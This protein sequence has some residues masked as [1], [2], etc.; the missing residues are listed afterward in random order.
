MAYIALEKLHQLQDGYRRSFRVAGEELVLLVEN[1]NTY[2]IKALCPHLGVSLAKAS[3]T[4]EGLRCSGHGMVF[5]LD[6]GCALNA[7][8]CPDR[9]Q[10]VAIAYE[11]NTLGVYLENP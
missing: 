11:G 8:D 4:P 2:L 1:G 10:F 7:G 3:L 5:S 6:T 9:L